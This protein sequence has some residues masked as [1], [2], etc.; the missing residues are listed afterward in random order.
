MEQLRL[1]SD[2]RW[3]FA[4]DGIGQFIEMKDHTYRNLTLEFLSTLHVE[5]TQ[6]PQCQADYISF[7]L[8]GQFYELNLSAFNDIF[9]FPPSLD[10]LLHQVSREFNLNAF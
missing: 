1:L 4:R 2:S 9:G 10:L 3:L 7:Y 5:V 8:Q 6:E